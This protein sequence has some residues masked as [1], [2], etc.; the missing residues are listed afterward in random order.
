MIE[1]QSEKTARQ[2]SAMLGRVGSVNRD[3]NFDEVR[4]SDQGDKNEWTEA[5]RWLREASAR[6]TRYHR[7]HQVSI[8]LAD[9]KRQWCEMI[10]QKYVVP[11]IHF[12]GIEQADLEFEARRRAMQTLHNNMRAALAYA[13]EEAVRRGQRVLTRIAGK[14]RAGQTKRM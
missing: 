5:R 9:N 1:E 10:H 12:E 7:E 8:T 3:L 13:S 2:F 4:F 14:V 6:V 11:R